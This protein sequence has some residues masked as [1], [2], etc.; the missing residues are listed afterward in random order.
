MNPNHSS[1][2]D[3]M[4]EESDDPGD[5]LRFFSGS[6]DH[7]NKRIKSQVNPSQTQSLRFYENLCPPF[8]H[9]PTRDKFKIIHN[10]VVGDGVIALVDFNPGDIVFTFAGTI[11]PYQTLFTLQIEPGQYIEDPLVMGKVLHSCDPN[12]ICSMEHKTYWA[13]KPIKANDY[14]FMDYESTEDQLFRHFSCCCGAVHCRGEIHGRQFLSKKDKKRIK[15]LK[16]LANAA[17]L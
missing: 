1:E 10:D 16:D 12:M 15:T 3:T 5:F 14:L 6:D 9:E 17:L 2:T 8:A 11:L 13:C 7:L 4:T